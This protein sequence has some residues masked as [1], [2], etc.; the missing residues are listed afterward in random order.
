M[1]VIGAG[2]ICLEMGSVWSRLGA[3]VTVVEFLDRIL[4][5][6]DSEIGKQTQRILGKQGLKFKLSTKVTGPKNGPKG[7]GD[8]VA[9][10]LETAA[11]RTAV[12]L[13]DL[14]SAV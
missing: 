12:A 7:K 8:G 3:E 13:Q 11:G 5:T 1:V 2:V 6:M 14:E 10:P 9:L 4:P